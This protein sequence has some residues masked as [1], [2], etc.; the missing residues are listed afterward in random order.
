MGLQSA[1]SL[2]QN[3]FQGQA[4]SGSVEEG[5]KG[6]KILANKHFRSRLYQRWF[7]L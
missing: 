2:K 4:G 7:W 6:D 3:M 5:Q 1:W